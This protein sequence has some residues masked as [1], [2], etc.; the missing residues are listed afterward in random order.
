MLYKGPTHEYLLIEELQQNNGSLEETIESGLSLLWILDEDTILKID[1]QQHHFKRNQLLYLTE[2]HNLE[3]I[4]TGKIR[5]IRFNRAFYC[6]LDHD[7]E[8][9]CKGILFFGASQLPVISLTD[10]QA[11][12]FEN[13]WQVFQDELSSSEHL[14]LEMLQMLLK[15]FLIL[16]TRIYKE[17]E[18]YNALKAKQVDLVREFNFLVEKHFREKHTVTEY[19]DM[20][21]KSPK[22]IANHFA[23]L[24]TKTPSRFIQERIML[25]ARRLLRYTDLSIKQIAYELGYDD[26]QTF[27]R[28][29]RKNEG[30]SPS[31]YKKQTV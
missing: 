31:E 6:I 8:V 2:F 10:D 27:S 20:L 24:D 14:Q 23:R 1:N 3:V 4:K 9:S 28:F 12:I 25:E 17:K 16:S 21:F 26:L 29:F 18:N 15:R 5:L 22:T 7:S 11:R 30:I 13:L 19:A